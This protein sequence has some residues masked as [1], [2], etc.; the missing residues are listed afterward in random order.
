[1]KD[2]DGKE[3]LC[4]ICGRPATA[5]YIEREDCPTCE[6]AVCEI[7]MQVGIDYIDDHE[8]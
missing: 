1:M 7:D 2:E 8:Y 6:R 5:Y 3:V 4:C